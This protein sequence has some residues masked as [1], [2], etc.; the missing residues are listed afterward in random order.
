MD[1]FYTNFPVIEWDIF[2]IFILMKVWG[3]VWNDASGVFLKF[4]HAFSSSFHHTFMFDMFD[5]LYILKE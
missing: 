2:D 1:D 4:I 5:L 3:C